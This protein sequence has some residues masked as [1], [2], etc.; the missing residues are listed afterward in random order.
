M[1]VFGDRVVK[2]LSSVQL[3]GWALIEP[4][5]LGAG[6]VWSHRETPGVCTGDGRCED[7]GEAGRGHPKMAASAETTP[8][9]TLI[10][11]SSLQNWE[12]IDFCCLSRPV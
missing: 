2:G 10:S 5:F 4:G 8:A 11:N 12:E 1:T 9:G 7:T 3:L 6:G